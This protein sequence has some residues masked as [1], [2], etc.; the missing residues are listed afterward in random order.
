MADDATFRP[1]VS[2]PDDLVQTIFTGL[3][4]A[5]ETSIR[6]HPHA[7]V[8]WSALTPDYPVI[9]TDAELM[10]MAERVAAGRL[11]WVATD[12]GAYRCA[13][14]GM[15]SLVAS[16]D[17]VTTQALSAAS[18]SFQGERVRCADLAEQMVS[19]A[20]K[21]VAMADAARA[22]ARMDRAEAA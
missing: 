22:A 8:S 4:A 9:H 6:L 14:A 7:G 19:I 10:A 2:R 11:A 20:A 12:E 21:I 15:S 5:Q 13:V 17:T 1:Q 16:L 18:R 3:K